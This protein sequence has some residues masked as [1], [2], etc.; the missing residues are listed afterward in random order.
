MQQELKG[1]IR[2]FCRVRPLLPD[3]DSKSEGK[4]FSFPTSMEQH[5]RGIDLAQ[6]GTLCGDILAISYLFCMLF[7]FCDIGLIIFIFDNQGKNILS[8]LTKFLCLMPHKKL[9]LKKFRSLYKVHLMVIRW[10]RPPNFI[11]FTISI[12]LYR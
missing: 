9:C 12:T 7:Y 1:N 11:W 2:V 8:H 4:I 5:E 10:L 6:N 3:E